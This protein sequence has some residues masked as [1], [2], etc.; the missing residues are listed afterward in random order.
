MLAFSNPHHSKTFFLPWNKLS[1]GSS[2]PYI[3][4]RS[5]NLDLKKQKTIFWNVATIIGRTR[6]LFIVQISFHLGSVARACIIW[7]FN[8]ARFFNRKIQLKYD[9]IQ[10]NERVVNRIGKIQ[11]PNFTIRNLVGINLSNNWLET[12]KNY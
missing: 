3:K 1:F 11:L 6:I 10:L 2:R 9:T 8:R 5:K 7:F 4:S 12:S